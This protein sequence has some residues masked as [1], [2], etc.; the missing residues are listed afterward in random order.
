ML[1]KSHEV[2]DLTHGPLLQQ[3]QQ[4]TIDTSHC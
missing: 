4:S 1:V 2:A 3:G